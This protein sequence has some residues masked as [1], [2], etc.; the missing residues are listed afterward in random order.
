LDQSNIGPIC[1]CFSAAEYEDDE[2]FSAAELVQA[3]SPYYIEE[4]M[5]MNDDDI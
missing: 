1:K 5:F 2:L 3:M 4:M